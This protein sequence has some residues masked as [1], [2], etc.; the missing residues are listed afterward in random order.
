MSKKIKKGI[1]IIFLIGILSTVAMYPLST[2]AQQY[3]TVR[4]GFLTCPDS[5]YAWLP[6]LKGWD[7]ELGV[8]YE[9]IKCT[10]GPEIITLLLSGDIDIG[11]LG[12]T[13]VITSNNRPSTTLPVV[14]LNVVVTAVHEFYA[15]PALNAKDL[16]DLVGKKVAFAFGTNLDFMFRLACKDY[17]LDPDKDFVLYNM[18]PPDA[19]V[20][21]QNGEVDCAGVWYPVS[22]MLI[23]KGYTLILNGGQMSNW[24]YGK[25]FHPIYALSLAR[26]DFANEH[27]E[28]IT[29]YIA[30][31]LRAQEYARENLQEVAEISTNYLTSLGAVYSVDAFLWPFQKQKFVPIVD[32]DGMLQKFDEIVDVFTRQSQFWAELG[33]IPKDFRNPAEYVNSTFALDLKNM[34]L[35]SFNSIQEA[36]SLINSAKAAGK[37][38]TQAEQLL[39]QAEGEYVGMNYLKAYTLAEQA[40]DLLQEKPPSTLPWEAI[41]AIIVV[42]VVF[43]TVLAYIAMR[44]KRKS[45]E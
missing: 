8:N 24:T 26:L 34:E 10:T 21:L 23:D 38:V 5:F 14:S 7:H 2:K 19:M 12:S 33:V 30:L 1:Y 37:T 15:N 9:L 17:G 36:R 31:T 6:K 28:L 40:I 22:K 27:P 43:I 39:D 29:Q 44:R 20:A 18:Q 4:I 25:I 32:I 35:K 45:R 13:P 3:P 16:K 42:V 41:I 11:Q